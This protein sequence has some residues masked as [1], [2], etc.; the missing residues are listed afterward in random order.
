MLIID[1]ISN[2]F[3]RFDPSLY[4]LWYWSTQFLTLIVS[5][6]IIIEI[7]NHAL[8]AYPGAERCSRYLVIALFAIIFGYVALQGLLSTHWSPAASN[9]ELERDL[10]VVQALL[11]VSILFVVSYFRIALGKNL[12]GIILGYGLFLGTSVIILAIQSYAGKS[13]QSIWDVSQPISYLASLTFW[14]VALWSY[15]PNPEP[16]V[17]SA[18][19][20]DYRELALKTKGMLHLVRANL[21]KAAR[22]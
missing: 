12:K 21:G 19:E 5:C 4:G 10:R 11:L 22:P 20:A 16:D 3:H 7:S 2:P 15:Q 1:C 13:F 6:G 17:P 9:A 18:L 8:E 14:T